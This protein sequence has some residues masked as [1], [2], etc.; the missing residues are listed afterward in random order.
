M[1]RVIARRA[2]IGGLKVRKGRRSISDTMPAYYN[3]YDPHKAAWLRQLIDMGLIAWG[4]V[5]ERSITEV[6]PGDLCGYTQHHFFAGIGVWSYALRQAGWP[7]DRPVWSASCPCQPFSAAG[8]QAGTADTRH[9]WP[10]VYRLARKSKPDLVI[11]EQVSSPLG[12]DWFDIV[13]ADLEREAYACGAVDSCAAGAGGSP[14]IRQ[15]LYWMAVANQG[16]RGGKSESDSH[17][18]HGAAQ[19]GAYG[20]DT[21]RRGVVGGVADSGSVRH[22][23]R[24]A[25]EAGGWPEQS[26]RICDA[27]GMAFPTVAGLEKRADI[28]RPAGTQRAAVVGS[29]A[30]ERLG[31]TPHGRQSMQR[32]ETLTR[33]GGHADG[34]VESQR[35]GHTTD[36]RSLPGL[37]G[38]IHSGQE[39]PGP[40]DAEPER[41]GSVCGDWSRPDWILT[42]PQRVGD[43]AGIRPVIGGIL[44]LLDGTTSAMVRSSDPGLA[45]L[46]AADSTSEARV[47]RLKGYGDAIVVPQAVDFVRVVMEVLSQ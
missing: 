20:R 25:R 5:D 6:Q 42:R 45:V 8:A 21:D 32:D 9:L 30:A 1:M 35:L 17:A 29:G 27:R 11:G 44:P 12:L 16:R 15:R 19:R 3:E 4:E 22:D 37:H 36:T 31:H 40:R 26:E 47:M 14:H 39:S 10:E 28:R 23:R 34:A 38:R 2:R 33:S 24:R 46:A 7:D 43:S 18:V 13:S 41:S